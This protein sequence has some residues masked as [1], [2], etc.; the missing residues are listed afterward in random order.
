ME[1]KPGCSLYLVG[2]RSFPNLTGEEAGS[3]E[4]FSALSAVTAEPVLAQRPGSQS[5][6]LPLVPLFDHEVI[7][8]ST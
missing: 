4:R 8:A 5:S 6:L 7:R 2:I 1:K 3:S